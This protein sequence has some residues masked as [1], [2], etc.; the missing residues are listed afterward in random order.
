MVSAES[1][2]EAAKEILRTLQIAILEL[3][4]KLTSRRNKVT[5]H[6]ADNVNYVIGMAAICSMGMADIIEGD[7]DDESLAALMINDAKRFADALKN[8]GFGSSASVC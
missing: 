3:T 8:N 1:I 7:C 5:Q 6:D 2:K 4:E